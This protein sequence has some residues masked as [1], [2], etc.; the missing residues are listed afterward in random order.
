[1]ASSI[2]FGTC[3]RGRSKP[4]QPCSRTSNRESASRRLPTGLSTHASYIRAFRILPYKRVLH[5]WTSLA[6][7][8]RHYLR[9]P[10]ALVLA[11]SY[12]T[13]ACVQPKKRVA[14]FLPTTISNH[15]LSRLFSTDL[16]RWMHTHCPLLYLQLSRAR[17]VKEVSRAAF[18]YHGVTSQIPLL[19]HGVHYLGDHRKNAQRQECAWLIAAR[20]EQT[21]G[22]IIDEYS[23]PK[24]YV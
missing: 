24:F 10:C 9:M 18:V 5:E 12:Q 6:G 16:P 8:V 14:D 11:A 1:M 21:A 15:S 7:L 2:Q 13:S 20:N 23:P 17:D 19:F 22:C 3:R 4:L